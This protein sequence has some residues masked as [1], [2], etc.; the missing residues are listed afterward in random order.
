MNSSELMNDEDAA[1]Y[2][3]HHQEQLL[4]QEYEFQQQR[5][6]KM[7]EPNDNEIRLYPNKYKEEG[8]NKPDYTG[9][10]GLI[11]GT[12]VKV[13]AWKNIS[14]S[15]NPYIKIT[16]DFNPDAWKE[17]KAPVAETKESSEVVW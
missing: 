10:D 7:F 2:E 3:Q 5:K 17:K 12:Q 11:K 4:Q 8:D 15:G 16:L 9:N 13:A 14:K 6:V 1:Q